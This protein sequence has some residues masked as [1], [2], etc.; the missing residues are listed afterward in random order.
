MTANS[1]A[2]PFSARS[3]R[4]QPLNL[5]FTPMN[6]GLGSGIVSCN[7][8]QWPAQVT[9]DRFGVTKCRNE[10]E[11]STS[12]S[13][14]IVATTNQRNR[15]FTTC[16]YGLLTHC[17]T[18]RSSTSTRFFLLAHGPWW[19]KILELFLLDANIN[20]LHVCYVIGASFLY[21][22]VDKTRLDSIRIGPNSRGLLSALILPSPFPRQWPYTFVSY[23]RRLS[24]I[25]K[26]ILSSAILKSSNCNSFQN[27]TTHI[28]FCKFHMSITSYNWLH[29]FAF[30]LLQFVWPIK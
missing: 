12:F 17:D 21:N 4:W 30:H 13:E 15:F 6:G 16:D 5:Q 9:G 14:Q 23:S 18:M 19:L 22:L 8:V 10:V 20:I 26:R 7:L 27:F 11:E 29:R 28:L 1:W 25:C 3:M 24:G 2:A